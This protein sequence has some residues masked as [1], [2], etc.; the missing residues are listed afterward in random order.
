MS[1]TFV[2]VHGA[3]HAGWTWRPVAEHLRAHGHVVYLPTLPGLNAGDQRADVHLADTVDYLVDYVERA[4]LRNAVLVGHSWGGFPVSGAAARLAT[5]LSRLVYWS[6]FV[7]HS[8]ETLIDLCPP[9]YGEMFRASAAASPDNSVM[10]PFEVFCA[11]FMQD[12]SPETQNVVYPLLER[13]PF[14]TMNEALDLDEWERL[15]LPSAYVLSKDDLALPPG[16]F[17]WAPRFP[18]RLPGAPVIYTP[19]SHESQ[20]TQPEALAEA[21]IQA[22]DG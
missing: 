12:A 1:R 5:R 14:H 3:C 13:Q 8:G 15:R 10:F 6:A 9:A 4:D 2:L 21:L 22:S 20:L 18:E 17:A 11:A 7:P 19:G 16:E